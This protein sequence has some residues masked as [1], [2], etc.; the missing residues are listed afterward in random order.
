MGAIWSPPRQRQEHAGRLDAILAAIEIGDVTKDV[1]GYLQKILQ[2]ADVLRSFDPK[3]FPDNGEG[4][5]T[6]LLRLVFESS[7][8]AAALTL[9]ILE[10]VSACIRLDP[11][12]V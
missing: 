6:L 8:G 7:N 3:R 2:R 10:A 11:P 9:P 12:N 5:V 1:R 4:R